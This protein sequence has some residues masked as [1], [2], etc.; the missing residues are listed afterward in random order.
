MSLNR[1]RLK[2]KVSLGQRSALLV[3]RMLERPDRLIGLILLGNNF[4][5]VLAS[6]VAT[7]LA[8]RFLG[9]AGIPLAAALLT[10]SILIFSEVTPKTMAA[11]A[12][13]RLAYPVAYFLWPLL[14][15]LWPVVWLVNIVAH[16]LL[17]LAGFRYEAHKDGTTMTADELRVILNESEAIL[18]KRH[19]R[20][21]LSILDLEHVTVE[22]IMVPRNEIVGLDLA[23]TLDE[24]M[25]QLNCVQ[26]TRLLLYE[27]NFDQIIGLVHVRHILKIVSQG[28]FNKST[29]REIAQDSYYVPEGTPL[30]VQM[31]NFQRLRCRLG[32][33]VD[34]YGDIQGLVTLEDIL[35]EI[36]GEFTTDPASHQRTLQR[37]PDGSLLVGGRISIRALNR[38][39]NWS[40][41]TE[42]PRTLN[43]LLIE[44][45][46][47]IPEPGMKL[48]FYGYEIEILKVE[49]NII[50]QVRLS[51]HDALQHA[52]FAGYQS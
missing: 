18:S 32:L 52:N 43:G 29:L 40:L 49:D 25:Q 41:P 2:H 10:M 48:N 20:M 27:N 6:M 47:N 34:E 35:E 44:H 12:P 15:L 38:A 39:L 33:V 50:K 51:A 24:I 37:Q 7:L 16:F 11:M 28:V 3:H 9:E 4:V 8:Y 42:G 30:N 45:L 22:D 5:N 23:H 21:L 13:D 36:V 14:W 19:S 17:R 46:E 26:H 31:L 1:Y